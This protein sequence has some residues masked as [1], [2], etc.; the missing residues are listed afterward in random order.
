MDAIASM[1]HLG[2]LWYVATPYTR[3]A[4]GRDAA[5]HEACRVTAR[6]LESG[7]KA[8]SPI[9][10]THPVAQYTLT[11]ETDHEFWLVVDRPFMDAAM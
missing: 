11:C 9:A 8:Y 2:G 3:Y 7:V 1:R 6:L 5:F 10:H 4:A